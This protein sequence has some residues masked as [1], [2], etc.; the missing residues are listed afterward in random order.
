MTQGAPTE[1]STENA[2]EF[3]MSGWLA[4]RGLFGK[5]RMEVGGEWFEFVAA[6]TPEQLAAFGEARNK[7]DVIGTMSALLADPDDAEKLRE[8]F[9]KQLTPVDARQEQALLV[10]IINFLVAGDVGESSAS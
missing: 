8:A 9:A 6:A 5:R 2:L 1:E 4:K 7:G 3:S 10:S